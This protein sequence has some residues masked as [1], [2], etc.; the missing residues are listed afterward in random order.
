MQFIFRRKLQVG[1][2]V[3]DSRELT[4]KLGSPEMPS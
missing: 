2:Q 1:Y 3:C 4:G